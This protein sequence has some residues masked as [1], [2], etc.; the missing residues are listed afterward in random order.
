VNGE[1]DR[2]AIV[3]HVSRCGAAA[4]RIAVPANV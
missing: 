3:D 4:L 2:S 1:G